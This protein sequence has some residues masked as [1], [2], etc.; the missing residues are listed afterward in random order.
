MTYGSN[1]FGD[2]ELEWESFGDLENEDESFN[3][4]FGA[5]DGEGINPFAGGGALARMDTETAQ[6]MMDVVAELASEAESEEEAD[7]FLPIIAKLAPMALKAMAPLAKKAFAKIAPKVSQSVFSAGRKML[8]NFGQK[9]MAALPDIARGVARDSVQAVADGRDVT[10]DMVIRSA[11]QHTLPFLQDPRQAQK[12]LQRRR[13]PPQPRRPRVPPGYG[14]QQHQ[15]YPSQP[16]DQPSYGGETYGQSPYG[17]PAYAPPYGQ[18]PY[19]QSPYGQ[20][21][22]GQSPYGQSP[23]GQSPY[24]QSPYGQPAFGQP[25]YPNGQSGDGQMPQP[26]YGQWGG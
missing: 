17:P 23:Y 12:A 15:P 11:A 26:H 9:G 1:G 4:L 13:R 19:G 25:D 24:G 7:A 20:S 22:H 21:P 3:D 2:P 6:M 14:R 10:G 5:S 8:Q 16:Y 18:S